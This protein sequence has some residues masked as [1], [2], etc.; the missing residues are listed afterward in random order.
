MAGDEWG[1]D[2]SRLTVDH[3][4][5]GYAVFGVSSNLVR[6]KAA[7]RMRKKPASW[8]RPLF[9]FLTRQGVWWPRNLNG[10]FVSWEQL[11]GDGGD[12]TVG[13]RFNVQRS[14]FNARLFSRKMP[15][16]LLPAARS[17]SP[18]LAMVN[19]NVHRRQCLPPADLLI[20]SPVL[21]LIRNGNRVQWLLRHQHQHRPPHPRLDRVFHPEEALNSASRRC[22]GPCRF[23]ASSIGSPLRTTAISHTRTSGGDPHTPL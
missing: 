16:N 3:P 18:A 23:V 8:Q 6:R 14:T 5:R 4:T 11:V 13:Q 17:R 7:I 10:S 20:F 9:P 12:L 21:W 22:E 2:R 15:G 19:S 1:R